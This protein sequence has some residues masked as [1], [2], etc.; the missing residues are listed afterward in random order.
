MKRKTLILL[1]IIL[2]AV[3]IFSSCGPG[4]QRQTSERRDDVNI[5]LISEWTTL[6]PAFG[7]DMLVFLVLSQFY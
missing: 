6:D 7:N 4:G 1:C 3:I 2:A 5:S